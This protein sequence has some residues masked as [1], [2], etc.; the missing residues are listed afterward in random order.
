MLRVIIAL[1]LVFLVSLSLQ[2]VEKRLVLG[3]DN[4]DNF[5][6]VMAN[7][8]G[9]ALSLVQQAAARNG[10]TIE[11]KSM[12]WKACLDELKTGK[13]DGVVNGSFKPERMQMGAYPMK[14]AREPDVSKRLHTAGY[15]LFRLKGA[16]VDYDGSKLLDLNGGTVGAQAGVSVV[17]QLEAMGVK[18][19]SSMSEPKAI[20]KKVLAGEL[21]AAALH[22]AATKNILAGDVEL[23]GKIVPSSKPLSSK[24]YYLMFSH[25]MIT[26][27]KV[28][29]ELIWG[30]IAE[31]RESQAFKKGVPKIILGI[32]KQ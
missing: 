8:K 16:A 19:D 26:D 28:T 32:M 15:S 4:Q 25:E 20:L 30:S 22:T 31:V 11:W 18:V 12:P 6:W 21:A 24:P 27:H 9:V 1:A 23:A 29:T 2:A 7:G 14:N 13:L 5:P 17:G 3:F 10:Y